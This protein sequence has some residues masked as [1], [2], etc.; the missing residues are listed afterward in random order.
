MSSTAIDVPVIAPAGDIDRNSFPGHVLAEIARTTGP[1]PP[2]FQAGEILQAYWDRL[3]PERALAVVSAA[4][5]E[6]GGY[7]MGAPVT[8]LRFQPS[9]DAYFSQAILAAGEAGD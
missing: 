2:C 5:G 6:H 9:H 8:P 7:W 1:Q 4:F 3:G